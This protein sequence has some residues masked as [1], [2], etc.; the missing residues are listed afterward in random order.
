MMEFAGTFMLN[1]AIAM[2]G[3]DDMAAAFHPL[4]V[5]ATIVLVVTTG[6]PISGAHYNPSL[7]VGFWLGGDD[8]APS[9]IIYI[10]TALVAA[11]CAQL[12]A[13]FLLDKDISLPGTYDEA[14]WM[15]AGIAEVLGTYL[16]ILNVLWVAILSKNPLGNIGPILVAMG[17]YANILAFGSVSGAVLNPDVAFGLWVTGMVRGCQKEA[18]K[19][20]LVYVIA[21]LIGG[22]LAGLTA[23]WILN[24]RKKHEEALLKGNLENS[25]SDDV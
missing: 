11:A 2:N 5:A 22:A 23:K 12:L 20:I 21:D 18:V 16:A 9:K 25:D 13:S 14:G 4:C 8:K 1:L 24:N 7:T 17:F 6:A 15:R 3:G 19:S 10:L